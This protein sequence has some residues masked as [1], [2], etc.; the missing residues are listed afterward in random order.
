MKKRPKVYW[1]RVQSHLAIT[2][3]C[4]NSRHDTVM[5]FPQTLIAKTPREVGTWI[6]DT[7]YEELRVDPMV[8]SS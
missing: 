8:Q 2:T 3:Y 1:L 7:S 5:F 4:P 6:V